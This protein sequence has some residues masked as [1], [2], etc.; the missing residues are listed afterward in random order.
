M[1]VCLD[2]LA[3]SPGGADDGT[4]PGDRLGRE[5]SDLV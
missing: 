2:V 5:K 3:E 4:A 1:A